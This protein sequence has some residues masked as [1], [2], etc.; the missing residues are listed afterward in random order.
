MTFLNC[1]CYEQELRIN[2]ELNVYVRMFF[3]LT[4]WFQFYKSK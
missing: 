1:Y 4:I 2:L 3:S